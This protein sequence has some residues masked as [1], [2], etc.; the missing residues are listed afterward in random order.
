[1][2]DILQ[3]D[4]LSNDSLFVYDFTS[5][6]DKYMLVKENLINENNMELGENNNVLVLDIMSLI[7]RIPMGQLFTFQDLFNVAWKHI[8]GIC[9]FKQ[10]DIIYDSYVDDWL[11]ECERLGPSKCN[12]LQLN[13]IIFD[14]RLPIQPGKDFGHLEVT[15][16]KCKL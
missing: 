7:R 6:T 9:K 10:I 4:L 15:K 16:K 12:L 14:T 8:K 5:N 3:Y 2:S 11:K 13:D 1:M